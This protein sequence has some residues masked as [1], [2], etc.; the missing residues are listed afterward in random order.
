MRAITLRPDGE[1]LATFLSNG[2]L[3]GWTSAFAGEC[4]MALFDRSF[5]IAE[6]ANGSGYQ[7]PPRLE[8]AHRP[9]GRQCNHATIMF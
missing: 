6:R 9:K 7:P 3:R 2:A 4:P 5:G 8:T 1:K